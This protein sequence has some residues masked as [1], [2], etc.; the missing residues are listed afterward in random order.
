VENVK[1]PDKSDDNIT[2]RSVE[3]S[4]E[5]FGKILEKPQVFHNKKIRRAKFSQ[6][7][8]NFRQTFHKFCPAKMKTFPQFLHIKFLF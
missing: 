5:K 4:M 2:I 8:E 1:K 6:L 7:A 3:K